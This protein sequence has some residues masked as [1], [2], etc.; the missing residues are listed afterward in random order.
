[1]HPGPL[2][3][4]FELRCEVH[5]TARHHFAQVRGEFGSLAM[6]ACSPVKIG[7]IILIDEQ[8]G[9]LSPIDALDE[10]GIAERS[11]GPRAGGQPG[12]EG[13]G[14]FFTGTE[15]EV[16]QIAA[17]HAIDRPHL[18]HRPRDVLQVQSHPVIRPIHQIPAG[19]HVV[20]DHRV[21]GV[22]ARLIVGGIDPQAVVSGPDMGRGVGGENGGDQRVSGMGRGTQQGERKC[23]RAQGMANGCVGLHVYRRST[24]NAGWRV[25]R[26]G[27]GGLSGASRA[28]RLAL[29]SP[30]ATF[31]PTPCPIPSSTSTSTPNSPCSTA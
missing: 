3:D 13:A 10:A 25:K 19:K 6:A 16:I 20:A 8:T 26:I 21:V 28:S 1:M 23:C 29:T 24:G 12:A 14:L 15:H 31:S 11:L 17:F 18:A 9:I 22:G 27:S 5:H 2:E 30:A 4:V 7:A